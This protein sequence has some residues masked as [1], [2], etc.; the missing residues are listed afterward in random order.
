MYLYNRKGNNEIKYLRCFSGLL[1]YN[2]GRGGEFLAVELVNGLVHLVLNDGEGVKV[3]VARTR[4]K[5]STYKRLEIRNV[6]NFKIYRGTLS[7]E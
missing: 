6:A 1:L 3:I 4:D 7:L 2:G 5:V